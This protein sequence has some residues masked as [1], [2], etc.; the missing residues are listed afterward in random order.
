MAGPPT[1]ERNA[2]NFATQVSE[3][4]FPYHT[5]KWLIA[6]GAEPVLV[7]SASE[8]KEAL[9]QIRWHQLEEL[10]MTK[11]AGSDAFHWFSQLNATELQRASRVEEEGFFHGWQKV[12]RG[13]QWEL[14]FRRE[15][16]NTIVF[17]LRRL[18]QGI[19]WR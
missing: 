1:T 13:R 15:E 19:R 6:Q 16:S 14:L 12:P 18:P 9:R 11:L 8:A 10:R 4:K 2:E 5:F 17:H 7:R 3:R